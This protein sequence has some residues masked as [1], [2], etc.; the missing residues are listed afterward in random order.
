MRAPEPVVPGRGRHVI[1]FARNRAEEL[2]ELKA[3]IATLV[4]ECLAHDR[5]P[6][7]LRLRKLG[8]TG[9]RVFYRELIRA[10]RRQAEPEAPARPI[11]P[12]RQSAPAARREAGQPGVISRVDWAGRRRPRATLTDRTVLEAGVLVLLLTGLAVTLLRLTPPS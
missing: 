10:L 1:D 3:R 9:Q 2:A 6:D 11:R 12:V 5:A 4:A 7:P 8:L